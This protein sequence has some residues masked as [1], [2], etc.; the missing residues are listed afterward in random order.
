ME[1]HARRFGSELEAVEIEIECGPGDGI[2][3]AHFRG[4]DQ[5]YVLTYILLRQSVGLE[6][7]DTRSMGDVQI[8]RPLHADVLEPRIPKRTRVKLVV[9]SGRGFDLLQSAISL[10]RFISHPAGRNLMTIPSLFVQSH[11]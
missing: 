2:G 6:Y 11:L 9:A 5:V 1:G 3:R 10:A 4:R 8:N 7:T